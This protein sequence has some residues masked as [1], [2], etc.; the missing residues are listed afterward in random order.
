MSCKFKIGDRV[1]MTREFMGR[2]PTC[3]GTI[4]CTTDFCGLS[5][6]VE[7][8]EY[9][10]GHTC[11]GSVKKG[12]GYF[13]IEDCLELCEDGHEEDSR[14]IVITTDGK[15]T[16][17]RLYEANKVI[18]KAEAKCAP[19]DV[20]DFETGAKLAFNRLYEKSSFVPHLESN[21]RYYGDIG[22]ETKY[23]DAVG[24]KLYVGD[25]I[26]LYNNGELDTV[27]VMV[28]TI[29]SYR[30]NRAKQFVNGIECECNDELGDISGGWKII[31]IRSFDEV[32]N[33]EEIGI[34]KYVKEN[35]N[36]A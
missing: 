29:L 19:D 13:V 16:L 11:D 12:Y 20:F 35:N 7:F 18:K 2:F 25:V 22:K 30:G 27:E 21:G 26:E 23:T 17:A 31:K 32:K 28:E 5:Y 4:K 9:M 24:R 34:F 3:C 15:T 10:S 36:G 1:R 33:G 14:K 8:D 6:G